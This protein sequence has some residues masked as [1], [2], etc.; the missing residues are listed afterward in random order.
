MG[1]L[2]ARNLYRCPAL[3]FRNGL[4]NPGDFFRALWRTGFVHRGTK[5]ELARRAEV[6]YWQRCPRAFHVTAPS[7]CKIEEFS[8]VEARGLNLWCKLGAWAAWRYSAFI[9][10]RRAGYLPRHWDWAAQA[11]VVPEPPL[12]GEL[13]EPA[14]ADKRLQPRRTATK[15]PLSTNQEVDVSGPVASPGPVCLNDM[16]AP[17][18]RNL[19]N[20]RRIRKDRKVQEPSVMGPVTGE[21]ARN[22]PGNGHVQ[23]FPEKG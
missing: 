11:I 14:H 21:V 6:G 17:T 23:Q 7:R 18:S 10:A 13:I 3:V 9:Y 19:Q 4:P 8:N 22:G 15:L 20:C 12:P 5:S 2:P 16:I 1:G